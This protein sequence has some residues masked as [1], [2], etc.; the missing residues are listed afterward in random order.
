MSRVALIGENS[1]GYI[2]VLIDIWNNGDCAILLDWKIPYLTI[3][4]MMREANV[5]KC[6]IEKT[7][8]E[9]IDGKFTAD[10]KFVEFDD[11]GKSTTYLPDKI[12]CKYKNNYRK[13]EAVV[14][15]SSGTTGK[16]KGIILSHFAISTNADNIIKYM[17]LTKKDCVYIAKPLSHS[18]T[19]T[20]EL[21]VALKTGANIVVGPTIVPPRNTLINIHDFGATVI[22]LNPTL[23]S[24]YAD[25]YEKRKYKITTLRSIYVSGSILNDQ[26]YKKA[27]EVFDNIPIYN[28]Y[29]LSEAGPR[30]T[31]QR[32]GCCKGNSVGKPINNIDVKIINEHGEEVLN[33]INGIIHIKTQSLFSGYIVGNI[34][35]K[36]LYEG[37]FNT[38]DI[39]YFD[40]NN[41]LHI[42][43][44]VDDVIII[45]SHKIYPSEIEKQIINH[46]EVNECIVVPVSCETKT[47]MVCL[48]TANEKIINIQKQLS[49]YIMNDEIPYLFI[50]VE[51]IPYSY[52]HKS[53][54]EYVRMIL[55]DLY[56]NNCLTENISEKNF[57]NICY[58]KDFY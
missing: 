9:K 57:F 29:G 2:N 30:V 32:L 45:N 23:L 51:K 26:I 15:Y 47:S 31:A 35:H 24:M 49:N 55:D 7:L 3:I 34:K 21:L 6:Y 54:R 52:C 20:G 39:G 36:S 42:V 19:L 41:E 38:G 33:G 28:V 22:C 43:D 56:K 37:W 25:E 13:D 48:Y 16:A 1:V 4:E 53:S 14:I 17:E 27:H 58:K 46:T 5:S 10:I 50:R 18:S 40:Y 44:R 8:Y 12:R 11:E